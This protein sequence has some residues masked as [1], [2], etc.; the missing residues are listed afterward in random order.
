MSRKDGLHFKLSIINSDSID[1]GTETK[2]DCF[3]LGIFLTTF[4]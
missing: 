3:N 2:K 4:E 1:L